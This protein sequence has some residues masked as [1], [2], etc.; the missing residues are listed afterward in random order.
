MGDAVVLTLIS[1]AAVPK[2]VAF[3]RNQGL[4]HFDAEDMASE[5]LDPSCTISVE[6][7]DSQTMKWA[8]DCTIEGGGTSRAEWQATSSGDSIEGS[9][10]VSISVSGQEMEMTS[11]FSG[12]NIGA[13]K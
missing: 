11:T 6:Q 10:K 1:T 2:L 3:Y 9:G 8:M 5:G 13:C 7:S 4:R 12:K